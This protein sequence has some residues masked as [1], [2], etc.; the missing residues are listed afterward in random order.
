[1]ARPLPRRRRIRRHRDHPYL[2]LTPNRSS[3]TYW[4][5]MSS[6]ASFEAA[7]RASSIVQSARRTNF[8]WSIR[9]I[10]SPRCCQPG[11][12]YRGLTHG[13]AAYARF[14]TVRGKIT[15]LI[16]DGSATKKRSAPLD[17]G[18]ALRFCSDRQLSR[19]GRYGTLLVRLLPAE[20]VKFS[21]S[22]AS[23]KRMPFVRCKSENRS[24]G[25]PA[26]ANTDPAIG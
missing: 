19:A 3:V 7:E 6:S 14:G 2:L 22:C 10:T 17:F 4:R 11:D 13:P 15:E 8:R 16:V 24:F 9:T 26:V 18:G 1:M 23:E 12:H 20:T 25:V 21:V 5:S